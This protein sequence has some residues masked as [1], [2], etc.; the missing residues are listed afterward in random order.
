MTKIPFPRILLFNGTYFRGWLLGKHV[1]GSDV[2]VSE[3]FAR[4]GT[5]AISVC[6]RQG[7]SAEQRHR[8]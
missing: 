6:C 3:T 4:S 1:E 8:F 5:H 2:G 7:W